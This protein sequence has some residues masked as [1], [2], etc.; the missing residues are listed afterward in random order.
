MGLVNITLMLPDNKISINQDDKIKFNKI[1]MAEEHSML[2][3][4]TLHLSNSINN[5]VIKSSKIMQF[6]MKI[7]MMFELKQANKHLSEILRCQNKSVNLFCTK[8]E[9]NSRGKRLI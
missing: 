9:I 4:T 6:N 8:L 2:K 7:A 3:I 5:L 1:F